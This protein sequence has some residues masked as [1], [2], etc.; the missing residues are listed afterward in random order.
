[1]QRLSNSVLS[2]VLIVFVTAVSLALIAAAWLMATQ[3][4]NGPVRSSLPKWLF[5][6]LL[7]TS[8]IEANAQTS[9]PDKYIVVEAYD[10]QPNKQATV[11]PS[12]MA[13]ADTLPQ[14]A[15]TIARSR[16]RRIKPEPAWPD[17][18][19]PAVGTSTEPD[20]SSVFYIMAVEPNPSVYKTG[21]WFRRRP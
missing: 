14:L 18:N 15:P 13:P 2:I 21:Y 3:I 10:K 17:D 5:V 12:V 6:S 1:M 19:L 20:V 7:V 9:V 11:S 4:L 8:L 16:K